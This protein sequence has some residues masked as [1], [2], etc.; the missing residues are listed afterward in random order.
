V[1]A[2]DSP[3]LPPI[4]PLAAALAALDL[5]GYA[6]AIV[7]PEDGGQTMDVEP[8][9]GD[10]IAALANL[11]VL[12]LRYISASTRREGHHLPAADLLGFMREAQ[13]VHEAR[14]ELDSLDGTWPFGA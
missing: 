3:L 14:A 8:D 4:G 5:V 2:D 10:I 12:L 7:R 6:A 1:S 13:H 9:Q 11:S